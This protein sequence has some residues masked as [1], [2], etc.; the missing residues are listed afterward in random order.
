MSDVAQVPHRTGAG[1]T[2]AY[3]PNGRNDK[4]VLSTDR[5]PKLAY[6]AVAAIFRGHRGLILEDE[7][8][9]LFKDGFV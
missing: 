8:L 3:R 5:T 1:S 6:R 7:D 2:Q 9:K 4:G